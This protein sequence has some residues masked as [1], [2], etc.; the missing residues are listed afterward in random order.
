MRGM[1]T[2]ML[3]TLVLAGC[4]ASLRDTLR[5]SASR[6]L[7]DGQYYPARIARDR[8]DRAAF[9]VAVSRVS[10]GIDGAREAGRYEA[11][12][13][14]LEQYG[15]SDAIWTVG[16]DSETLTV[17]DDQLDLAGRCKG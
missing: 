5:P 9:A 10:Q 8:E 2:L 4:G 12:K 7:F 11:T 14:C 16:P 13:Y 1:I 17:R 15:N 6:A 3:A